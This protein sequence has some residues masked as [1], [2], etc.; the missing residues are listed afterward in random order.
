[1]TRLVLDTNVVASALLWNGAPRELLNATIQ[2]QTIQVYS[3]IPLLH[4]LGDILSR[5]K[6]EKKLHAS[7]LSAYELVELFAG[8]IVVVHPA[9]ISRVASDPDDDVVIGT[10]IAA[11]CDWIVSGDRD[12]LNVKEYLG[13]RFGSVSEFM[14][15]LII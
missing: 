8:I 4:E 12:L 5:P 3:S 9:S 2:Q 10:A 11:K 7:G 1:M 14:Q 15:E 6:F 13:I